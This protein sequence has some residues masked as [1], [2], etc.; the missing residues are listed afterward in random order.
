M[1]VSRRNAVKRLVLI[2][3]GAALLPACFHD[4]AKQAILTKNFQ[5]TAGQDEQLEALT[6]A[7]IP[8][9]TTPGAREV[10]AHRFVLRMLDDCFSKADR[11]KYL[12]GLG[13]LDNVSRQAA[14][15]AFLRLD[16]PQ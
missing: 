1:L 4:H 11:D 14:G 15:D 7:I 8:S 6:A 12:R 5:L 16:P 13:Q 2:S 3:A 9:G 10:S